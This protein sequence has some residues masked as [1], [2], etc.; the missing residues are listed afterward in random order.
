MNTHY[1]SYGHL[2][3]QSLNHLE[4]FISGPVLVLKTNSEKEKT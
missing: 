1:V 4:E 2:K 3:P